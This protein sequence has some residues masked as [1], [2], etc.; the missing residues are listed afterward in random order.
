MVPPFAASRRNGQPRR[1]VVGQGF[2]PRLRGRGGAA[3]GGRPVT[4]TVAD[5]DRP[6]DAALWQC[7]L[8]TVD[9]AILPALRPGFERDSARQLTGVARYALSRPA[10]RGA[11]LAGLL[12][13]PDSTDLS[14]CL[15]A[16]SKILVGGDATELRALLL[17][18]LAEDVATAAP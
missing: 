2:R 15:A 8:D 9:N 1:S 7:V 18:Y 4:G 5:S 12:E 14:G 17:R 6:S 16:A 3:A 10:D 13:L 11:E